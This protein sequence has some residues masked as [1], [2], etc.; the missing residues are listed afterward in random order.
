MTFSSGDRVRIETVGDDG[1]PL[2]RYGFVGGV[3]GRDGPV[4]VMLDGELGGDVVDL[5]QLKPV[6]VNTV[7]LSLSGADL[8]E[9]PSLRA[10]LVAQQRFVGTGRADVGRRTVRGAGDSPAERAG[11]RAYPRRPPYPLGD[12]LTTDLSHRR[13]ESAKALAT[14]P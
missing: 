14:P 5:G 3:A 2:I 13:A 12:A 8:F 10:G 7:E 4:V 1:L 6:A 9:D 11:D